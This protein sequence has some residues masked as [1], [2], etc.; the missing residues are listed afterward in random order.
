MFDN[1]T[2]EQELNN[3]QSLFELIETSTIIGN[4]ERDKATR[5]VVGNWI[6]K[7]KH[8]GEESFGFGIN[9]VGS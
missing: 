3:Q 2:F 4:F 8:I 5:E 9:A 6:R 1:E 7:L